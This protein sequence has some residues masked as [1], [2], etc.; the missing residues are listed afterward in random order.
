M[1][2]TATHLRSVMFR[3]ANFM[4]WFLGLPFSSLP[5][6]TIPLFVLFAI[7]VAP[8]VCLWRE[9]IVTKRLKIG[10]RGFYWKV[11]QCLNFCHSEF[12][13]EIRRESTWLQAQPRV[14]WYVA[15]EICTDV[16]LKRSKIEL[17]SLLITNRKS[18][19]F[20][21]CKN[22]WPRM[23]T[24]NSGNAHTLWVIKR[25]IIRS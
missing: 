20:D 19:A 15:F 10:S 14:D 8:S 25:P 1:F 5:F 12:D 13:E 24:L 3:S 7:S 2:P 11:V 6:T 16:S 21:L 4:C 17:G 23:M 18:W 22:R 9:C